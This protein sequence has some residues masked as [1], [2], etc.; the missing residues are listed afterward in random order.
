MNKAVTD[1]SERVLIIGETGDETRRL[2]NA[3]V[4]E[5]RISAAPNALDAA[6]RLKKETFNVI[7]FDLSEK[8]SD[9]ENVIQALQ[10]F[11]AQT[12]IIITGPLQDSELIVKAIKAGAADFITRPIVD[13]KLR[14]AVN[15]AI[16]K[17]SMKNEI[18]YLRRQ[19]DVV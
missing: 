15:Q 18:N 6:E 13:E 10:Q 7:I 5:Y 16:E 12:P 14:L 9:P 8:G 17:Q 3:L 19:Q 4:S 11:T 2:A 1:K